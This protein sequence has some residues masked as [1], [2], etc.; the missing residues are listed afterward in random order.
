MKLGT[1][2]CKIS[3]ILEVYSLWKDELL[4]NKCYIWLLLFFPYAVIWLSAIWLRALADKEWCWVELNLKSAS[5]HVGFQRKNCIKETIAGSRRRVL[6]DLAEAAAGIR[7]KR[8]RHGAEQ[9]KARNQTIHDGRRTKKVPEAAYI[10]KKMQKG[11]SK[12][13]FRCSLATKYY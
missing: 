12:K 5:W 2:F 4:W 7:G 1:Y 11:T 10:K 13:K 3:C 8:T 6:L 9:A